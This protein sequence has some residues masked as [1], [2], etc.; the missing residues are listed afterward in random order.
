LIKKP[1]INNGIKSAEV[2]LIDE[3]GK[4]VGVVSLNKALQISKE[5]NLDLVQITDKVEPPVCKVMDFGK[6]L[7][8]Q[9]KKENKGSRKTSALKGLRIGF[10]TSSHDLETKARTAQRFLKKGDKVKIEM[11][12]RGREKALNRIATEKI[13][14]FIKIIG[15]ELPIKIERDIKR[16]PNNLTVIIFKE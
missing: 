1:P 8:R 7:Y 5:C 2:R 4:Q 3:N 11:K 9:E 14:E 15:K 10:N 6:Y 13:K 16:Q 12:L